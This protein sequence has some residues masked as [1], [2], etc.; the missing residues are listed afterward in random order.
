MHCSMSDMS[1]YVSRLE[2]WEAM[3]QISGVK[4]IEVKR[5]F[6]R[7]FGDRGRGNARGEG[8][9]TNMAPPSAR[10]DGGASSRKQRAE[11]GEDKKAWRIRHTGRFERHRVNRVKWLGGVSGR[12]AGTLVYSWESCC[13]CSLPILLS[14]SLSN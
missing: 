13:C 12:T 1:Q 11:S 14:F 3:K 4:N 8:P 2:L 9:I 6:V 5:G 7:I 10:G